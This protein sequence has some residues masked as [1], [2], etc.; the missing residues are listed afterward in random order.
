MAALTRPAAGSGPGPSRPRAPARRAAPAPKA[1]LTLPL[2]PRRLRGLA[3]Q[4]ALALI[5]AALVASV[6]AAR[7]PQRAA[8]AAITATAAAGFEVR[9]VEV[10]GLRHQSRAAI[11]DAALSGGSSATLALDLADIRARIEALPWTAHASV[12]RRLPGRL[13][14]AVTER[15]PAA[16]WQHRGRLQLVDRT[17]RVLTPADL[18][19]FASLPLVVGPDAHLEHPSLAAL[20]E[21]RPAL[22]AKVDAA[23]WIG[24][25]RW[26][27]RMKTGETLA[28]P[29]GYGAADAAL[30]RFARLDAEKPLL[31]QG[32]LRFDLRLP[33]KMVV[34]LAEQPA[35]PD[36]KGTAI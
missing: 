14:I 6:L 10:T 22:A 31:G 30:K 19:G 24:R 23:V 32:Y 12:A 35:L 25:R 20:L 26:D 9:S 8:D 5:A 1:T 28:L 36:P 21:T 2:S 13:E 11:L 16:I 7:L 29:E 17:G 15:V 3:L 18:R 27:L 34:R 4:G 33:G